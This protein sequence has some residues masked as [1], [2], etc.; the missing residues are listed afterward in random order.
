MCDDWTLTACL[1]CADWMLAEG[2]RSPLVVSV[3]VFLMATCLA[4][5]MYWQSVT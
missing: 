2:L 5:I 1:T 4:Q 3:K